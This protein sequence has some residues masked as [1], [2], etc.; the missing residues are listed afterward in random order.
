MKLC[1]EDEDDFWAKWINRNLEKTNLKNDFCHLF[2][3]TEEGE[4]ERER[5]REWGER[6]RGDGEERLL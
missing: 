3:E 2:L 5:K 1:G 6:E 4:S